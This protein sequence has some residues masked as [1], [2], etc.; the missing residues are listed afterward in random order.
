[1]QN[2][3]GLISRN[4]HGHVGKLNFGITD[5]VMLSHVITVIENSNDFF[6]MF[7]AV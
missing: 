6:A 1:M 2:L 5:R 7:G 3:P 4:V